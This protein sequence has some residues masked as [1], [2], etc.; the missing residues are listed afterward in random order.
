MV[1]K[2]NKGYAVYS[3]SGKKLSKDYSSKEGAVKRLK[4]IEYFKHKASK[5]K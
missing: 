5:K 1:R 3:H 2:T 4:Q